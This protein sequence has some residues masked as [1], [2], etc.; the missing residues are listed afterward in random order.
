MLR[1]GG[2]TAAPFYWAAFNVMGDGA[3]AIEGTVNDN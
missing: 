3:T 2:E 1:R